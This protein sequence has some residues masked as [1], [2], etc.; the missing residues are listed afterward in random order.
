M[1]SFLH[2]ASREARESIGPRCKSLMTKLSSACNCGA[3]RVRGTILFRIRNATRSAPVVDSSEFGKMKRPAGVTIIA[4]AT[5]VCA[6]ILAIG[7]FTFFFVAVL[8][9]SGGDGGDPISA[10]IAGMGAAGGFSLLVLAGVTGY[11]GVG[12]LRMEEWAR[13]VT[14]ASITIGICCTIFSIFAFAGHPILPVVPMAIGYILIIGA[15]VAM[16][17]YLAR[18]TVK[19]AFRTATA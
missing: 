8:A 13:A 12:V 16:L 4:I 2:R 15:A 3:A 11:V 19:Q 9:I 5:F 10:S 1:S 7:A 17:A 18:P 6:M 14:I